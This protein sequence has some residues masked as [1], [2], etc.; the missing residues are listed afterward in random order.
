MVEAPSISPPGY[1][2]AAPDDNR[3]QSVAAA[4]SASDDDSAL[5]N[6][7]PLTGSASFLLG[8]LGYGPAS[9]EGEVQLKLDAR[10][11]ADAAQLKIVFRGVERGSSGQEIELVEHSSILWGLGAQST[12]SSTQLPQDSDRRV[13]SGN[14]GSSSSSSSGPPSSTLFR[15]ELTP[16]LPHCIHVGPSLSSSLEY[17]LIA[18]L[19]FVDSAIHPRPAVTHAM[20]VHLARTLPPGSLSSNVAL[21]SMTGLG[22]DSHGESTGE[23]SFPSTSAPSSPSVVPQIHSISEPVALSLRL[24]KTV[25]TRSEPVELAVKVHV[26]SAEIIQKEGLRLRTISAELVRKIS[27]IHIEDDKATRHAS[28]ASTARVIDD[29]IHEPD[30]SSTTSVPTLPNDAPPHV[31]VLARSGKS[32]RFSLTRPIVIRLLLHPPRPPSCESISQS[33]ILHNISFEVR[34]TIGLVATPRGEQHQNRDCIISRTIYIVPDLPSSRADKQKE[35]ERDLESDDE[36]ASPYPLSSSGYTP[37]FD[38]PVPSYVEAEYSGSWTPE[39]PPMSPPPHSAQSSNNLVSPPPPPHPQVGTSSS[40]LDYSNADSTFEEEYDGYEDISAALSHLA[41][42]PAIDEDVSPPSPSA[43]GS[44]APLS[45]MTMDRAISSDLISQS[46]DGDNS[47]V[48]P[49][50]KASALRFIPLGTSSSTSIP[51]SPSSL[52]AAVQSSAV[53]DL[54]LASSLSDSELRTGDGGQD[55]GLAQGLPPPYAGRPSNVSDRE[56][57]ASLAARRS[58]REMQVS[59]TSDI[60]G[61]VSV[62]RAQPG[63]AENDDGNTDEDQGAR[64]N[65]HDDEEDDGVGPPPEYSSHQLQQLPLQG[66]GGTHADSDGRRVELVGVMRDGE[67]VGLLEQMRRQ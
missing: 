4:E 18:M 6:L 10:A 38:G 3:P 46:S 43:N 37:A 32:A 1:S 40:Y 20:P 36:S 13:N 22:N 59:T 41:P 44:F 53:A 63:D 52:V 39:P 27:A 19:T 30:E 55:V 48:D 24:A 21:A 23:T 67:L 66:G 60:S 15:L 34:V 25:F 65:E 49:E 8:H 9:L 51:S 35:V 31:T 17:T 5:I 50:A 33:T 11:R 29:E 28:D 16:D 12:S 26:P 47:N 42:P 62:Q 61:A 45:I 57:L 54:D 14:L 2:V 7:V 56:A 58:R 64:A